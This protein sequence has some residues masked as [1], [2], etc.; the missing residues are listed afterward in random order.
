MRR[1]DLCEFYVGRVA[2]NRAIRIFVSCVID[3][4]LIPY[5]IVVFSVNALRKYRYRGSGETGMHKWSTTRYS[6]Y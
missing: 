1:S 4:L 3:Q 6:Y 2:E 5:S